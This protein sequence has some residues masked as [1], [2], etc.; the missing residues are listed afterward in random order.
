MINL[1]TEDSGKHINITDREERRMWAM[2]IGCEEKDLIDAVMVV[3]SSVRVV[4]DY[5]FLNRKKLK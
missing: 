3:G 1:N 5:L 2:K 4:D